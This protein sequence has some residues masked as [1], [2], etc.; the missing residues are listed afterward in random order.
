MHI[1]YVT[2]THNNETYDWK[3]IMILFSVYHFSSEQ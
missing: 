3:N 2:L 1:V